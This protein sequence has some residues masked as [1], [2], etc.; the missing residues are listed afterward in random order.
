MRLYVHTYAI[1]AQRYEKKM[2][3]PNF[4]VIFL[5]KCLFFKLLD[6]LALNCICLIAV[7][8]EDPAVTE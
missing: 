2:T 7:L 3:C 5:L 8:D 1:W 6:F 4:H